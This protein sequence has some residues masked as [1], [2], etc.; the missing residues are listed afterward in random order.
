MLFCGG[1]F[2]YGLEL[3]LG[4]SGKGSLAVSLGYP[5]S[6]TPS[7]INPAP[8]LLIWP[9]V[10]RT[11]KVHQ[12]WVTTRRSLSFKYLDEVAAYRLRI[13]VERIQ[14]GLL[15]LTDRTYRT[16]LW[17]EAGDRDAPDRA[18]LP[19]RE[20]E[21]APLA[22]P[23]GDPAHARARE[24]VTSALAGRHLS[25]SFKLPG[26][27][28]KAM[29]FV[30]GQ[31]RV[32]PVIKPKEGRVTWPIPLAVMVNQNPRHTLRFVAEFKGPLEFRAPGQSLIETH[33]PTQK[34]LESSQGRE[35]P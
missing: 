7:R 30:L 2:D 19:G 34:E 4:P 5:Q 13:K 21:A 11:T 17:L 28:K 18:V 9:P 31:S 15:G 29:P 23:D 8:R 3:T 27:V 22:K 6:L 1:C 24:L 35:K 12:G 20:Q 16:T 33:A 14:L 32:D 26:V 10:K 25:V